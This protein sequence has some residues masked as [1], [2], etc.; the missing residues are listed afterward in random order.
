VPW[1][2]EQE[3]ICHRNRGTEGRSSLAEGSRAAN[4]Q[5]PRKNT[6]VFVV[7]RFA[8]HLACGSEEL[9]SFLCLPRVPNP[10]HPGLL[11]STPAIATWRLPGTPGMPCREQPTNNHRILRLRSGCAALRPARL[12]RVR[13]ADYRVF[14][15]DLHPASLSIGF[16]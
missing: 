15:W 2:H 3:T 16:E 8:L 12:V 14:E 11:S 6:F 7:P 1:A 5:L 9:G 4:A 13:E 10:V